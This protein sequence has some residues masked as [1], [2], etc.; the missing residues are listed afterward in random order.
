MTTPPGDDERFEHIPWEQVGPTGDRN[1]LILYGLAGAIL[2]AGLTASVVGGRGAPTDLVSTPTTT[3][4]AAEVATTQETIVEIPTTTVSAEATDDMGQPRAWS[5]ADL[6]AFPAETLAAEAAALAEWLASDFFTIDGG[7]QIIDD[8]EKVLPQ[9]SALPTAPSGSL[10]FVEWARAVS[11]QESTPGVY[12]VLVVVRRLAASDGETYQ[13]IAPIGVVIGLSWTE[14]GWSVTDLPIL[15]DPPLLVQAPAW[16]LEEVP[17]EI[18]AAAVAGTGGDVLGGV[19]V[20]EIWRLVV[21]IVDPTGVSWPV[22]IWSDEAG[23]RV[24]AQ[25]QPAQP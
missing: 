20:G 19:R 23:I 16:P 6:L 8:L 17:A 9:G 15:T 21:A 3:T 11:V 4:L 1:K 7:T 12:E 2:I 14:Q 18:G 10:S 13:R 5:E 24:P 25:A 22:V